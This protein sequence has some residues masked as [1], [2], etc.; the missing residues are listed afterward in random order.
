M[1]P[2]IWYN[3]PLLKLKKILQ[4]QNQQAPTIHHGYKTSKTEHKYEITSEIFIS[5]KGLGSP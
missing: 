4:Y 2:E 1:I 3:P 5:K